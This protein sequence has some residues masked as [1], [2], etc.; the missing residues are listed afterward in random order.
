MSENNFP[1]NNKPVNNKSTNNKT[2]NNKTTSENS[3]PYYKKHNNVATKVN[4]MSQEIQNTIQNNLALKK[5]YAKN[6]NITKIKSELVNI[7]LEMLMTIKVYHWKTYSYA[8]HKATDHLYDNLNKNID[9]FVE[10]M[11]GKNNSRLNMKGRQIEFIDPSSK[12]NIKDIIYSYR[13]ILEKNM[14]KYINVERDTDLLNI[15]DD[16]LGQLNQFL[17]LS[18]F[19]K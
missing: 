17:Y 2:A 14:N 15:R 5:I 1:N 6:T 3:M 7:F 19:N 10:I 12:K 11:L 13:I 9:K 8:E 4:E 18:T 16:I